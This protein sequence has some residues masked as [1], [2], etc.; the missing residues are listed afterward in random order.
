MNWNE[1]YIR[2]LITLKDN[3]AKIFCQNGITS[4]EFS[5]IVQLSKSYEYRIP[6]FQSLAKRLLKDGII[7]CQTISDN[8]FRVQYSL[9]SLKYQGCLNFIVNRKKLNE[10]L[11]EVNK[12]PKV[13][14]NMGN[15]C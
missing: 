3:P 10:L 14:I 15:L 13:K 2:T 9:G 1:E 12:K 8:E 6:I 5:I 4:N 7:E 11:K